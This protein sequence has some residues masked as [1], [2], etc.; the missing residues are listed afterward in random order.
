M[1]KRR[2]QGLFNVGKLLEAHRQTVRIQV[3]YIVEG[4]K[5]NSKT[6]YQAFFLLSSSCR[7][8]AMFDK[9]PLVE[10]IGLGPTFLARPTLTNLIIFFVPLK[11]INILAILMTYCQGIDPAAN[12]K[13]TPICSPDRPSGCTLNDTPPPC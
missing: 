11:S 7:A 9:V 10:R 8:D 4:T 5:Q 1:L 3:L 2:L 13:H 12:A 6:A